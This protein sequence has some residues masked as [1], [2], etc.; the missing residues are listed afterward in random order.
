MKWPEVHRSHTV[1]QTKDFCVFHKY[2]V[3]PMLVMLQSS[4]WLQ[5]DHTT[6]AQ[7]LQ[8]SLFYKQ[9]QTF[10]SKCE[11]KYPCVHY[12]LLFWKVVC[13]FLPRYRFEFKCYIN[14][15]TLD[16][17]ARS[18]FKHN[19]CMKKEGLVA[20]TSCLVG[21]SSICKENLMMKEKRKFLAASVFI[22][23]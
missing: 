23:L 8:V 10:T 1:K 13:Y 2:H 7:Y 20:P 22:P 16:K 5:G 17:K 3:S 14:I 6:Y 19:R 11:G 12:G 9:T 18:S 21:F 15:L 4:C